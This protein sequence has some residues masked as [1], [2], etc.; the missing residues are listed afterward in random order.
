LPIDIFTE[1]H[2]AAQQHMRF[3]IWWFYRDLKA[4]QV[5]PTSRRKAE[6]RARFDRIFKR[7][8]G[9]VSL[10]RLLAR[11]HANKPELLLALDRPEIPLHTN[12]S[13]RDIRFRSPNAKSAAEPEATQ[14]EIAATPSSVSQKPAQSSESRLGLFGRP[15]R[16]S[17]TSQ[18]SLPPRHRQKP[19]PIRLT[20]RP[21]AP[22]TGLE[23]KALIMFEFELSADTARYYSAGKICR[24]LSQDWD[25]L[26]SGWV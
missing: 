6:L 18:R 8:T 23:V 13:E 14:A 7:R 21:F 9:F 15:A 24:I 16:C 22:V 26:Q 11:L 20:A 10:D 5:D 12:G 17:Q 1:M 19:M 4:C 2:R 25:A 3:L